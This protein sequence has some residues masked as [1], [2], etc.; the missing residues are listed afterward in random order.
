[1]LALQHN[2]SNTHPKIKKINPLKTLSRKRH[3]P[4]WKSHKSKSKKQNKNN[5]KRLKI[6]NN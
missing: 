1:M 2:R 6:S 4:K 5:N 3:K